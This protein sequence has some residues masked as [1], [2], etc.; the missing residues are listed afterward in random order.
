MARGGK[1]L[2]VGTAAAD[3]RRE[4]AEDLPRRVRRPGGARAAARPRR[5]RRAASTG[6]TSS[7]AL[8]RDHRV[9][10]LDFPGFGFSDKP[11]GESYTLARDAS[12]STTTSPR[13]WSASGRGRRPRPRRQ[14]RPDVRG[15]AAPPGDAVRAR[16]TSCSATGTCSCRCRTSRSSSASCSIRPRRPRSS[17]RRRRRPSR[18]GMGEN[19][20]TPP[21]GAGRP[22]HR[23]PGP[24]LRRQRRHRGAPRHDPVPR[25]ALRA[26][27]GL[28]RR[29]RRD[30][31]SRRRWCGACTTS[32][33]RC[34][35]PA[36]VW[37][38]V[39]GHQAGRQ[40][41]L[42]PPPREPLPPARSARRSSPRSCCR[43]LASA[44]PTP[45][46]P[47]SDGARRADPGRSL[48]PEAAH[49]QR[50]ARQPVGGTH[51]V[52]YSGYRYGPTGGSPDA[53]QAQDDH[54]A[55]RGGAAVDRGAVRLSLGSLRPEVGKPGLRG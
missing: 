42:A 13:C 21:R 25:R 24:H 47:L 16:A 39:P 31:R 36:H 45:P 11:K 48:P 50:R 2:R 38:S 52:G 30:R 32:S 33:R 29:A 15:T 23:G 4:R 7:D 46:G 26:R 3:A 14:R 53:P 22:G 49:R 35:S 43:P 20:F 12:W 34:G 44:L 40:Q 1:L 27:G 54:R 8:S 5:S 17:P 18:P 37:N 55:A 9:C 6:T 19:T 51:P 10:V 28:A 41:V